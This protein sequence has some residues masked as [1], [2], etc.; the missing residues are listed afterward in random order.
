MFFFFNLTDLF[1]TL[2][3]IY[4]CAFN[5]YFIMDVCLKEFVVHLRDI[6]SKLQMKLIY[7]QDT[8]VQCNN[9]YTTT[10]SSSILLVTF[11][12][13]KLFSIIFSTF[14]YL[15][16]LLHFHIPWAYRDIKLGK[17]WLSECSY[18]KSIFL[19][20]WWLSILY[21]CPQLMKTRMC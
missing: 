3:N 8:W 16:P 18:W 6:C 7:W 14:T 10:T 1:R 11:F 9:K 13:F 2:A 12:K 5:Y 17:I 20:D 19:L 15:F 21:Y 4:D